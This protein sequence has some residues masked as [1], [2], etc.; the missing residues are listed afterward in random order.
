MQGICYGV[1]ISVENVAGDT[2]CLELCK[3]SQHCTWFTY[4]DADGACTLLDGCNDFSVDDCDT[5]WSGQR[6]CG[7]RKGTSTVPDTKPVRTNTLVASLH[8]KKKFF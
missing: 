7:E 5:C 2:E 1:F 4:N 8:F 6:Q 3:M